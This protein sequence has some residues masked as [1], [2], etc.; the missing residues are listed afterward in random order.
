MS[1]L[2]SDFKPLFLDAASKLEAPWNII[3]PQLETL[4]VPQLV[5]LIGTHDL[6][7]AGV[8]VKGHP[9]T[10]EKISGRL[11]NKDV[12]VF[13]LV[14]YGLALTILTGD[15][16]VYLENYMRLE[17]V[18]F[19]L[20]IRLQKEPVFV[21]ACQRS[22]KAVVEWMTEVMREAC[23]WAACRQ[24]LQNGES[25]LHMAVR[26]K[27]WDWTKWLLDHGVSPYTKNTDGASP[28]MLV[29]P[30]HEKLDLFYQRHDLEWFNAL[31]DALVA[32]RHDATWCVALLDRGA[33]V[34]Q[35]ALYDSPVDSLVVFA[36]HGMDMNLGPLP[37][38]RTAD[39]LKIFYMYGRRPTDWQHV[40][41]AFPEM[42]WVRCLHAF[43]HGMTSEMPEP[44]RAHVQSRQAITKTTRYILRRLLES[45]S[46]SSNT[47]PTS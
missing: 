5:E 11:Q 37:S 13:L 8:F 19:V 15:V 43:F 29:A 2:K 14:L 20:S 22:L 7:V 33:D 47:F 16:H 42:D 1:A 41:A 32:G 30:Y 9:C 28:I 3:L 38:R 31:H 34:N 46:E 6:D 44:Y 36:K 26:R 23:F 21:L 25:A 4:T 17:W 18:P 12:S 24:T 10:F 39:Q 40:I 35:L 27:Q 45:H